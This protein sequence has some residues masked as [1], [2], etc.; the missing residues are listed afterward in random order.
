MAEAVCHRQGACSPWARASTWLHGRGRR[1]WPP[2]TTHM[3]PVGC[4]MCAESRG[5]GQPAVMSHFH[6]D[7][8]P[9]GW[10]QAMPLVFPSDSPLRLQLTLTP[11]PGCPGAGEEM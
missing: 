6:Q 1:A 4:D 2:E 7:N 11:G 5:W 8:P 3:S 9:V 10:K